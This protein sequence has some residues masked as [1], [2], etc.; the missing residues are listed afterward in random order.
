MK[1]KKTV[2]EKR[3]AANRR[4]AKRS[5][6]PRTQ[7]GKDFSKFNAVR[8][9]L[10]AKHVVIPV[11]DGDRSGE[12]FTELFADLR[13][14][15]HPE[16]TL[17][18]FCVVQIAECMWRFR[19]ATRAQKGSAQNARLNRR[20]PDGGE[21]SRSAFHQLIILK[22]AQEEIKTTGTLSP[23]VYADVSPQ[24][25]LLRMVGQNDMAQAEEA[26]GPPE[27][28]IDDFFLFSLKSEIDM[29]SD[30]VDFLVSTGDEMVENHFAE[31]ALPPEQAMNKILRYENAAQ[32][33]FDW[34]LQR[35]LESQQRRR[36]ALAA[37][38]V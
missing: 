30:T 9:G 7:P 24:L 13:Q 6:G 10:F 37:V 33:K 19:R 32:K 12:E 4:N 3:L 8:T 14:E 18:D 15:F 22:D 27:P 28:A 34:A 38:S 31:C 25:P 17:E 11:C 5:T 36:A 20:P 35:L 26:K 29:R 16:G 1:I 21:L 23:A 2:T